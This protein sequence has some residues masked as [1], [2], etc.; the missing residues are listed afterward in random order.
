M[1]P[2]VT[3]RESPVTPT[4]ELGNE[5]TNR[6]TISIVKRRELPEREPVSAPDDIAG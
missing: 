6:S 2:G 3:S 4:G 1:V 5:E